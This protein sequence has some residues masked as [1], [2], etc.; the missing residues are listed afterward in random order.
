MTSL[1]EMCEK[2]LYRD[3]SDSFQEWSKDITSFEILNLEE[4]F[5]DAIDLELIQIRLVCG[6]GIDR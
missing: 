1:G 3:F 6:A 4:D 5:E 2:N